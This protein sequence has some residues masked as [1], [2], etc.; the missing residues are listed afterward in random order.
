MKKYLPYFIAV[1]SVS[2]A[3]VTTIKNNKLIQYYEATETLLEE[4]EI[5]CDEWEVSL[6]DTLCEGDNWVEYI[7]AK[8]TV[9]Q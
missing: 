6:D 4:I 9:R 8:R 7:E 5:L 1:L 2:F 3:I